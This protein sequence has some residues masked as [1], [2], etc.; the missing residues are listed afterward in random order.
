MARPIPL[1]HIWIRGCNRAHW[2][3]IEDRRQCRPVGQYR[4]LV[5]VAGDIAAVRGI[6]NLTKSLVVDE[7]IR[8]VFQNWATEIGAKVI[9]AESRFDLGGVPRQ[10]IEVIVA[11]EL[12]C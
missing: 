11:Q 7:E 6:Q 2:K 9:Q 4:G 10:G 1:H 5:A 12:P 3:S 8:L